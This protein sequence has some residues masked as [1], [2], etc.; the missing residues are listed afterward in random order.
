M[1]LNLL[2]NINAWRRTV[3]VAVWGLGLASATGPLGWAAEP[4]IVS[5]PDRI[6]D[7]TSRMTLGI[8]HTH[9]G[10][11]QSGADDPAKARAID[12]LNATVGIQNTHFLGWGVGDINPSEGVYDWGSLDRRVDL[13][14]QIGGP[15]MMTI[16]LAPTWIKGTPNAFGNNGEYFTKRPLSDKHDEFAALALEVAKRYPHIRTFQVWNEMK[17]YWDE[18]ANNWDY[19]DY[20][21]MYNA[22]Y[23][24]LKAY[25]PTLEVGGLY[26]V[27]EG[28][29]SQS[30]GYTGRDTFDPIGGRN[31]QVIDYWLENM[32]GA[33][34][35]AVDRGLIDFHDPN[36]PDYTVEDRM[37]LTRWFGEITRDLGELTDLP[38]TWSEYYAGGPDEA[39]HTLFAL[40]YKHMIEA[41]VDRALLWNPNEGETSNTLFSDVRNSNGGQPNKHYDVYAMIAEY[42][43]E[44]TV[45]FDADVS[46]EDV[47]VLVSPTHTMLINKT[48]GFL[49]I[50][51]F[52][53]GVLLRPYEVKLEAYAVPE[54]TAAAALIVL[55]AAVGS[56]RSA[57]RRSRAAVS[58]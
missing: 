56:G 45:L 27:V 15:Q 34:F 51:L 52:G 47:E 40:T 21:N 19:A 30:R 17:G 24:T 57:G 12:L 14:N 26:L 29:G 28:T 32:S 33:D 1:S 25:D 42:F 48:D 53:R 43:G 5:L 20:T 11:D 36:Q 18:S 4:V 8:T 50:D 16:G 22:V 39:N 23:D 3:S 49:A 35:I 6:S 44:G 13:M 38:V 7:R 9:L 2:K 58:P 54:P 10:L 31:R 41:G 55:A 37:A 46:S